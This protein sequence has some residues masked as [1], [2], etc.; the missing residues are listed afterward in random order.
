MSWS[1]ENVFA[2]GYP[3]VGTT[4]LFSEEQLSGEDGSRRESSQR[5]RSIQRPI[6]VSRSIY[7]FDEEKDNDDSS[8]VYEELDGN[9]KKIPG[10]PA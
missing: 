2:P 6:R 8:H 3:I 5:I 1:E 9:D 7:T 4:P 10:K